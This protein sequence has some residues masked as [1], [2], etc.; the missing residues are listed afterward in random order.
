MKHD[1]IIPLCFGALGVLLNILLIFKPPDNE[2]IAT[3][4]GDTSNTL[5]TGAIA[6]AVPNMVRRD[7]GGE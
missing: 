5:I 4:L 1:L 7:R 3:I 6:V 2:K